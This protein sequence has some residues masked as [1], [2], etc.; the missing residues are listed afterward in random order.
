[1]N[2]HRSAFDVYD[3]LPSLNAKRQTL[4]AKRY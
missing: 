1:M 3:A 2:V 4:N